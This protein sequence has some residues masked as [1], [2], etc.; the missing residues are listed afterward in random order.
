MG[1]ISVVGAQT[2]IFVLLFQSGTRKI[3]KVDSTWPWL[4]KCRVNGCRMKEMKNMYNEGGVR[5]LSRNYQSS[6]WCEYVQMLK[7]R[8]IGGF[9]EALQEGI[10]GQIL[11]VGLEEG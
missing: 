4:T 5:R 11:H 2:I 7:L 6:L 9:N 10:L 3:V 1:N 8:P